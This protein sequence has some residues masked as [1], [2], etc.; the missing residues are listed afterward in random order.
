MIRL[1]K[2]EDIYE[3]SNLLI[4]A[5]DLEDEINDMLDMIGPFE[6]TFVYEL[7]GKIVSTASAIPFVVGNK[8]GRYIYAVA[9][10]I[11]HRGKGYAGEILKNIREYYKDSADVLLLRPAQESLFD[12]YRKKGFE[13]EICADVKE[14]KLNGKD[15]PE[16]IEFDEYVKE[17][18]KYNDFSFGEK[19]M[20]FYFENYGYC[21]F[22]GEDYLLL[23]R[24]SDRRGI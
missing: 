10:D 3:L 15:F 14:V 22:K 2:P 5:F 23:C 18:K 19:V 17:R 21:A 16:M 13:D 7:N 1:A 20:R 8:K 4:D 24:V 12:F 9:T 6:N 11:N